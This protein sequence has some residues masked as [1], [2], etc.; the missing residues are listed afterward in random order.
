MRPS[1]TNPSLADI[2][3]LMSQNIA[4]EWFA[5]LQAHRWQFNG[6]ALQDLFRNDAKRVHHFQISAAGLTLD[7]SKNF[8]TTA[9]L[10]A[11]AELAAQVQ[12]PAAV[13]ALIHGTEVN[14]TEHRPALHTALRGFQTPTAV[15]AEI[16]ETSSRLAA[17]SHQLRSGH[18][19]G[20]SGK[21][22]C[23]VVNIGIGGSD[24]GPRMAV[25]ALTAQ[26]TT[27]RVHFVANVDPAELI[28][29]LAALNPE[30]TLIITASK[31]FTTLETLANS[32]AA[33]QWLQAA[34]AGRDISAQLVA[35]TASPQRARQ[36]GI[37]DSNIFPMWDWVG[38][39]FSLWS[40]IGLSIAIAIGWEGFEQMLQGAAAMDSHYA[41][42]LPTQNMPMLMA[43]LEC[44]YL[45]CWDAHS[46]AVLPYAHHLRLFPAFLQQ[47][48]MESLGKATTVTGAAVRGHTG[49]VIWGE[50]GTNSQHSFMQLLHQGTRMITVDF[51]LPLSTDLTLTETLTEQHAHLVASCLSQSRALMVGKS[52]ADVIRDLQAQGLDAAE[53]A[54]QAPHRVLPGNHPSNTLTMDRLSPATLGAL[55][56][57]YEHKVHTQSVLW[58]INAF[59]QWGVELG[60]KIEAQIFP[61]LSGSAEPGL[62]ESTLQLA[63]KYQQVRN[64]NAK[65]NT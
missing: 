39:R 51:I 54:R 11:F 31:T 44:W 19:L 57:L 30:T 50:P 28:E 60:K 7:Y 26:Q 9:T 3:S 58:Q 47:L 59:D 33:R 18:Y 6:I 25:A 52:E 23:D 8:C 1:I 34:A 53:I 61:A 65:N 5:D 62:D 4:P 41:E 48:S 38:G 15:R 29:T 21:P 42:A 56:A 17:F 10:A 46:V 27:P 14:G 63:Q 16:S 64:Q 2:E 43:L 55:I 37:E 22:I 12:L 32:S 20:F 24:L 35:I 13:Q 49:A 36:F 45:N 40:A